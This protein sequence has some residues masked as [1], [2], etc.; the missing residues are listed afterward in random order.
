MADILSARL[1]IEADLPVLR[2]LMA[3]AIAENLK[4]FLAPE[5]IKA[6]HAIMGLDHSRSHLLDH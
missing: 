6:S 4:P 3:A 5:Q 1:A 2:E